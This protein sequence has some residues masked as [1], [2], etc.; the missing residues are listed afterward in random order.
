MRFHLAKSRGAV[1][2]P[3]D[4]GFAELQKTA[5]K[6][7]RKSPKQEQEREAYAAMLRAVTAEDLAK[8]PAMISIPDVRPRKSPSTPTN[9]EKL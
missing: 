9:K 6:A 8:M 3:T 1:C 4:P 5:S 7:R 2:E